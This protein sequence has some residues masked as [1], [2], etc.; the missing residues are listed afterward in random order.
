MGHIMDF[1]DPDRAWKWATILSE[2]TYCAKEA[3]KRPGEILAAIQFGGE[4]GLTPLQSLQSI[5]SINGKPSIY[6]D[7]GLALCLNSERCER[8]SERTENEGTEDFVAICVA[9]RKGYDE[10]VRTFSK[11]DAIL[12]GLWNKPGPWKTYPRR[13]LQMRARSFALRDCFADI[14][15]GLILKEEAQDYP[16]IE[17]E[18]KFL[19]KEQLHLV[20]RGDIDEQVSRDVLLNMLST[21]RTKIE[22]IE[23]WL[24]KAGVTAIDELPIELVEKIITHLQKKEQENV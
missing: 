15:K 6:G 16:T 23:K 24:T 21:G 12:A 14:L 22:D 20:N 18:E 17:A 1:S 4:I 9:K 3:Y 10:V 8:V 13:M 2:T 19:R 11:K 7:S 5:C